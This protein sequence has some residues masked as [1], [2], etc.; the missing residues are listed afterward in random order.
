MPFLPW[1][2]QMVIDGDCIDGQHQQ[3]VATINQLYDL[4]HGQGPGDLGSI[5]EFLVVYVDVHFADEERLM[6]LAGYPDLDDHRH[7]HSRFTIQLEA[8]REAFLAGDDQVDEDL[9]KF[10]KSWLF[11]HIMGTDRDFGPILMAWRK[12]TQISEFDIL[13]VGP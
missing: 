9:L 2:E 4:V 11:N 3:L 10:L 5:I 8:L 1:S 12:T 13:E 7:Q 6:R